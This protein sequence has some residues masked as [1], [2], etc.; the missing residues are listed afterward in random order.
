MRETCGSVVGDRAEQVGRSA[1][2]GQSQLRKLRP[3]T[4]MWVSVVAMWTPHSRPP[5]LTHPRT[6]APTH[7][8]TPAL[9]ALP[10]F[11]LALPDK[12]KIDL[13]LHSHISDGDLS[14]TALVEAA[15]VAGLDLMALTDHDTAAGVD[16]A[17]EAARDRPLTV[18]PGLE[19]STCYTPHE[20]HVLGYWVNTR[21]PSI[22]AHQH[23]AVNR[24]VERMERMLA[25][26][27]EMGVPV[28]LEQVRVAAGPE[29]QTLGRPHLARALL[30]GGHIKSFGEA[31]SRYIADGGP[32]FVSQ[33]FPTPE[34][35]IATIHAGG[36][37]AVW[38]HPPL[39]VVE[40]LLPDFVTWGLDGV[41]CFRPNLQAGDVE[42]L[43]GL[44]RAHGLFPTG[45]SDWHGPRRY[46]ELGEFNLRP[47]QV[48][49][50]LA[51]GGIGA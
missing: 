38:A 24:R 29:A 42:R 40:E 49:D 39:D 17:V 15:V 22:L 45:G 43:L 50:L 33:D 6:H 30:A 48:A 19:I 25:R 21:A 9:L 10:H 8:R 51:I 18:V 12:M 20:L 3:A 14:P 31:F 7:S 37:V 47:D 5:V 4:A 2:P 46:F 27:A 32:A 41:E 1:G 44:A 16:E 13:H 36:G 34:E 26:L 23:A 11:P 28:T 35:A